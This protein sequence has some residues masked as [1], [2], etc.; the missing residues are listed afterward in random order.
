MVLHIF[1]TASDFNPHIVISAVI[2]VC[3]FPAYISVHI[4]ER[5]LLLLLQQTVWRYEK[6][7]AS[8]ICDGSSTKRDSFSGSDS[9]THDAA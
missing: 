9:L 1:A 6:A 8:L 2:F 3:L 4:S 5:S 7:F